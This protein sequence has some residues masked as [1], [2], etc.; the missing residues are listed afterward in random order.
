[1]GCSTLSMDL[2]TLANN[3]GISTNS[4]AFLVT[5]IP[6]VEL[7]SVKFYLCLSGRRW[8]SKPKPLS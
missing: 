2:R 6:V 1:M 8:G 4:C 3:I 7:L 5:G